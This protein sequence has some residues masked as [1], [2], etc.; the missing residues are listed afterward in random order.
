MRLIGA[1]RLAADRRGSRRGRRPDGGF[2]A[3]PPTHTSGQSRSSAT[4]CNTA[5]QLLGKAK[6]RRTPCCQCLVVVPMLSGK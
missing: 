5:L 1:V 4:G 3:R 2:P 6:Q